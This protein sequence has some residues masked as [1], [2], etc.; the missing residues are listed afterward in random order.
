MG[1]NKT[2]IVKP[3]H[4]ISMKSVEQIYRINIE[5]KKYT[6]PTTPSYVNFMHLTI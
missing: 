5:M 3:Q 6:D 1:G 2:F 4:K